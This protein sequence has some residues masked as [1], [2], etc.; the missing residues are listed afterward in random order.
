MVFTHGNLIKINIQVIIWSYASAQRIKTKSEIK[1]KQFTNKNRSININ[2]IE[3][4]KTAMRYNGMN[5]H[6]HKLICK[7]KCIYQLISLDH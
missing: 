4:N 3:R 6:H 2:T 7:T 5:H 1:I